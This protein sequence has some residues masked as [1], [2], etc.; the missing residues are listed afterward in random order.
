MSCQV[1]VL[2]LWQEIFKENMCWEAA[3]TQ[4]LVRPRAPCW[5]KVPEGS[6]AAAAVW[7]PS[8]ALPQGSCSSTKCVEKRIVWDTGKKLKSSNRF[9]IAGDLS[10]RLQGIRLSITSLPAFAVSDIL[11]SWCPL[12]PGRP[13]WRHLIQLAAAVSPTTKLLSYVLVF[14]LV[15]AVT[16][17]QTFHALCLLREACRCAEEPNTPE[18]TASRENERKSNAQEK[19]ALRQRFKTSAVA[20]WSQPSFMQLPWIWLRNFLPSNQLYVSNTTFL[21]GRTGKCNYCLLQKLR[22]A[23]LQLILLLPLFLKIL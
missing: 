6:P 2:L 17:R 20:H 10:E 23:V 11:P 19:V 9:G 3:W 8:P 1:N 15:C 14:K 12:Q 22:P 4:H 13:W 5:P 21:L 16:Y 18:A 7:Q